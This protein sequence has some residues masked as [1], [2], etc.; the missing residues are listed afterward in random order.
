MSGEA[1]ADDVLERL[2]ADLDAL[3][4]LPVAEQA[5]RLDRAHRVLVEE[6]EALGGARGAAERPPA[7]EPGDAWGEA[8]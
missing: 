1:D 3:E 8:G 5:E 2:R 4:T 7:E 6:L